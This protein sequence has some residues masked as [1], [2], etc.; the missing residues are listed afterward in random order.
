[1]KFT[2]KHAEILKAE[3]TTLTQ[4]QSLDSDSKNKFISDHLLPYVC[5]DGTP[6]QEEL[7]EDI[8]TMVTEWKVGQTE[9]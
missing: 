3:G 4:V 8:I 6:E 7:A 1:M 9:D 2:E 5:G